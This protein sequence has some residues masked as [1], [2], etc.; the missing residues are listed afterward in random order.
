MVGYTKA[1]FYL[2]LHV[3]TESYKDKFFPD[4][5]C[6][7]ATIKDDAQC[8][9]SLFIKPNNIIHI[10]C[11]LSFC[12]EWHEYNITYELLYDGPNASLIRFSI[13]HT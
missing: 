3:L 2:V 6:L 13:C 12:D 5:E 8:I 11:A 10:K 1:T 7:N 4:G 9:T